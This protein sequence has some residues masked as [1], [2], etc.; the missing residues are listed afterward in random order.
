MY[1]AKE[2]RASSRPEERLA[3]RL[4]APMSR[5]TDG[6]ERDGA[7]ARQHPAEFAS[8]VS[9]DRVKSAR[10][11]HSGVTANSILFGSSEEE[12]SFCA[13]AQLKKKRKKRG[14]TARDKT[15]NPVQFN[16]YVQ[17]FI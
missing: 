7:R 15:A 9:Y 5:T 2:A 14:H 6:L 3:T 12:T 1:T 13:L 16:L 10:K 4:S 11:L 17:M 8:F